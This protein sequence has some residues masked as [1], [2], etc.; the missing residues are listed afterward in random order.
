MY[1]N[2]ATGNFR[3]YQEGAWQNCMGGG[4]YSTTADSTTL[5]GSTVTD[6]SLS[7]TY[8]MPANYCTSGRVIHISANGLVVE[9]AATAQS[10]A[11]TMFLGSVA[12]SNI[13]NSVTPTAG[14]TVG[15][16]LDYSFTCRA[17]PSG[18]S[19]IYG[20][21]FVSIPT[22]AAGA[23]TIQNITSVGNTTVNIATNASQAITIKARIAGTASALNTL[24]LKQMYV[25]SY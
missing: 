1:Y 20:Q 5:T 17:A 24:T 21:G 13:T 15:W 14:Q 2:S 19:A 18:A 11:F 7:T 9:G 16:N 8:A 10:I 3:C 25:N 22:T 23:A 4:L 6:Q 12:I